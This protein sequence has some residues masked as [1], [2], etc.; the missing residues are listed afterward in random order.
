MRSRGRSQAK[1][2]QVAAYDDVIELSSSDDELSSLSKPK[3]KPKTK[4]AAAT[5]DGSSEKGRSRKSRDPSKP[6]PSKRT[7]TTH[8]IDGFESD[9]NTIP[10]PTSDFPIPP[11]QQRL[12]AHIGPLS[13]QLP[14]SDP[15]PPPSTSGSSAPR[16]SQGVNLQP[17]ADQYRDE[18]PLSSPPPP[19]PR[20]R[21][22]PPPA[23][24]PNLDDDSYMGADEDSVLA[25]A[26]NLV[27]VV[28]ITKAP[29]KTKSKELAPASPSPPRGPSPQVVPE[30]QQLEVSP[31][32][33]GQA[34]ATKT[35][36]P[37]SVF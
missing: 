14:P 34:K 6:S 5:K 29:K 20:K 13:S 37:R 17:A 15:P 21:K 10:M 9:V 3:S 27:P 32:A 31:P 16:T 2:K 1:G 28:E 18:S 23:A 8:A 30:T 11:Q 26:G 24:L 22:R 19:M 36:A 4:K 33:P 25:G 12:P 7:K 35:S